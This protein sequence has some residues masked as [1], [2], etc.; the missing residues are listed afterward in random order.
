MHQNNY[1]YFTYFIRV[2]QKDDCKTIIISEKITLNAYHK[3]T[4]IA[5]TCSEQCDWQPVSPWENSHY[6]Q[7]SWASGAAVAH[8]QA[9][10]SA[11]GCAAQYQ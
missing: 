3:Y 4:P 9:D 8:T 10:I 2:E 1:N 6:A 7:H 11:T 5:Q